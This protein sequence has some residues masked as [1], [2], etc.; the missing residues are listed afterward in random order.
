MHRSAFLTVPLCLLLAAG[1]ARADVVGAGPSGF[2]VHF[3]IVTHR[4]PA[5][6]W[7]RL[8]RPQDWWDMSHSYGNDASRMSLELSPGGCWCEQL[9]GGGFVRHMEVIFA[10]PGKSLRLVGGLGPLQKMGASGSLSFAL[11][12]SGEHDTAVTVDYAVSGYAAGGFAEIAAG[13]NGV[14]ADQLKRFAGN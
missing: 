4:D 14:L 7:A 11:T 1:A 2:L 8:A 10:A 9:P 12:A 6:A 13:V 3:E 5:A